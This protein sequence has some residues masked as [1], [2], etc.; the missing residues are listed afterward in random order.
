MKSF[1]CLAAGKS[2]F[3]FRD[4]ERTDY[5]YFV[6]LFLISALNSNSNSNSNK[7][8]AAVESSTEPCSTEPR[9]L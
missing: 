2:N 1:S 9:R 7:D 6:I 5:Y 3:K 4:F 8:Y